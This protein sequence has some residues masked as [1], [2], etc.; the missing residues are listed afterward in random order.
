[1]IKLAEATIDDKDIDELV[2]WLKTYPRLTKG[3]L[4][5]EFEDKWSNYLGAKHSTFVNSGSSANLLML[6]TLIEAG[7]L[8][9]GDSVIVPAL[10]W[11]TD[12][13]PVMQ[14]GL[15]PLLCDCNTSDYSVDLDHFLDLIKN[16]VIEKDISGAKI[17]H[18]PKAA[19][20]VPVLGLAPNMEYISDICKKNKVILLEDCC[21]ALGS[22]YKGQKLG[23]FGEMSTFST[24]FGH[25]ISTIEGGVVCTSNAK[26]NQILKCIR[27]HGW[28]RDMSQEYQDTL[29]GFWDVSEFDSLYTFYHAGFNVRATDLQAFLGLRQLDKID[30]ISK[31]RNENLHYYLKYLDMNSIEEGD[32]FISNFAFPMVTENREQVVK[33]LQENDIEVRPM[34]CGSMG[35]Q[36][37]YVKKYGECALP[38]ADIIKERGLYLPNHH[39]LSEKDIK[40]ICNLIKDI[41]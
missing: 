16:G 8:E 4:T 34:I 5:I 22:E 6:A 35:R 20:L 30:A 37:F 1:M 7:D 15:K 28:D 36:P 11:A 26:Y 19:I 31:V 12:L 29:R 14:L 32:S 21:E 38:N 13:A 17:R 27:S 40:F 25:H 18:R 41:L 33:I 23:T 9:P 24:Y 2:E 39:L 3:S 10:S